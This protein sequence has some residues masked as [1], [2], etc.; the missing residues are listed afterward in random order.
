MSVFLTDVRLFVFWAEAS[1]NVLKSSVS[2][3]FGHL[4]NVIVTK[5][6]LFV[7]Q[8]NPDALKNVDLL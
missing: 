3:W 6:R 5:I 4:G 2:G 8:N 1:L 7:Q